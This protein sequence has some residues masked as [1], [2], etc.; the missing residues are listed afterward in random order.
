MQNKYQPLIHVDL[1]SWKLRSGRDGF[2]LAQPAKNVCAMVSQLD[3]VLHKF[4]YSIYS[5]SCLA[6]LLFCS[7][8]YN[9]F[10]VIVQAI[11][12]QV[13]LN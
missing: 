13:L 6:V 1:L 12:C 2:W 7:N 10:S 3:Q 5:F 4:I 9:H 11:K 8:H